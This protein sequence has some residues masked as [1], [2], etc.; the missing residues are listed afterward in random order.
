MKCLLQFVLV[1]GLVPALLGACTFD[2]DLG[3]YRFAGDEAGADIVGVTPHD[4]ALGDSLA[5]GDV[6]VECRTEGDC[7]GLAPAPC[8]EWRCGSKGHCVLMR[9]DD[10][11]PCDD[12]DPC[13]AHTI[14]QDGE[15]RGEVK[16]C[17]HTFDCVVGSCVEGECLFVADDS[18]CPDPGVCRIGI[19]VPDHGCLD[20]D[21][22][23]ETECP[24]PHSC[25]DRGLCRE[26]VCVGEVSR[27][28][29]REDEDCPQPSADLCDS[30]FM[31][32]DGLCVLL[33]PVDCSHLETDPCRQGVCL[34]EDGSCVLVLAEEGEECDLDDP[35]YLNGECSADGYCESEPFCE[36]KLCQET[37]C[38][39]SAGAA[40]CA[41]HPSP[42]GTP[43]DDGDVATTASYCVGLACVGVREHSWRDNGRATRFRGVA[44]D[45]DGWSIIAQSFEPEEP[46]EA[47][48]VDWDGED[49]FEACPS[50]RRGRARYHQI[51]NGIV[52]G[53]FLA[54]DTA[55]P[56]AGS[57]IVR[58]RRDDGWEHDAGLDDA[59]RELPAISE[60]RGV[61]AARL[62]H[63]GVGLPASEERADF[64]LWLAGASPTTEDPP[65]L[66]P[67]LVRCTLQRTFTDLEI[68][69]PLPASEGWAC[70]DQAGLL[71]E[72]LPA[73]GRL[74]RVAL[75]DRGHESC[76][77]SRFWPSFLGDLCLSTADL[78]A[79]AL[80]T[81]T[82]VNETGLQV[83]AQDLS[84]GDPGWEVLPGTEEL[85][86]GEWRALHGAS[87]HSA[88][89]A[90]TGGALWHRPGGAHP[91]EKLGFELP[92]SGWDFGALFAGPARV[93]IAA[94]YRGPDLDGAQIFVLLLLVGDP[95]RDTWFAIPLLD[96]VVCESGASCLPV[97]R[98]LGALS[99]IAVEELGEPGAPTGHEVVV[100]GYESVSGDNDRGLIF[101]VGPVPLSSE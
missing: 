98:D 50:G 51:H 85:V 79:L 60:L 24:P 40:E 13:T 35:C 61:A 70:V 5:A 52:V 75:F 23:D 71:P 10:G 74:A 87:A 44:R 32:D 92:S 7:A 17:S 19:C 76:L 34:P 42:P 48:V 22:P 15:C 43:C 55:E 38:L 14:C 63:D 4:V 26:G 31:C 93:F 39:V 1:C 101:K 91:P 99:G 64:G 73:H 100:V 86:G 69:L 21:V 96:H 27:C 30:R 97:E 58:F 56:S 6:L 77:D 78:E 54:G 8:R 12:D 59:L 20:K 29:C 72:S 57:G 83:L 82:G 45:P 9:L 46:E 49:S 37:E 47:L 3:G 80:F 90:G 81:P 88:W 53:N 33:P 16:A 28:E 18:L 89:A 11:T 41:W 95:G 36:D 66:R 25:Y 84:D 68:P 67:W 2:V 94:A 62:M 65:A